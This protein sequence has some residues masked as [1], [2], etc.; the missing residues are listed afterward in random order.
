MSIANFRIPDELKESAY[1]EISKLGST[2]TDVVKDVFQYIVDNKVL[3]VERVLMTQKEIQNYQNSPSSHFKNIIDEIVEQPHN[4]TVFAASKGTGA[5]NQIM[6][7]LTRYIQR[8]GSNEGSGILIDIAPICCSETALDDL[9]SIATAVD[10]KVKALNINQIL[11]GAKEFD[12]YYNPLRNKHLRDQ[13][14]IVFSLDQEY[15][16]T[17]KFKY[18]DVVAEY[19]DELGIDD[20]NLTFAKLEKFAD[21]KLK[22]LE[23]V[24]KS[25]TE[26]Q[27]FKVLKNL[28]NMVNT[29]QLSTLVNFESN[30]DEMFFDIFEILTKGYIGIFEDSQHFWESDAYP[31]LKALLSRDFCYVVDYELKS[32]TLFSQ[33][34]HY[35][36]SDDSGHVTRRARK[37]GLNL[38]FLIDD[39]KMAK[40]NTDKLSEYSH[41]S[42]NVFLY[43][44]PKTNEQSLIPKIRSIEG[45]YYEKLHPDEILYIRYTGVDILRKSDCKL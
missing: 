21:T 9:L 15:T 13:I 33:E 30:N 19:L 17:Q 4:N 27:A 23:A 34:C 22:T 43:K 8:P 26:I 45:T 24:S 5:T 39:I 1:K 25:E 3:P 11:K 2:P 12:L 6:S 37:V 41:N 7:L 40:V 42:Q 16:K 10:R 14:D 32:A 18:A 20:K 29:S 35:L 44:S 31:I 38:V 28:T 36:Y